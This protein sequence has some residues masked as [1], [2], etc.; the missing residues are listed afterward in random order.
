MKRLLSVFLLLPCLQACSSDESS[1]AD[2]QTRKPQYRVFIEQTYP[3]FIMHGGDQASGFE[4]ELLEAIAAKEGF[5]LSYT[6]YLWAGLFD[7]LKQDQADILSAGITITD[8]RKEKMLFS[9]PHFETESV[10][11]VHKQSNIKSFNDIIGKKIGAKKGTMQEQII[12]QYQKGYGQ[13]VDIPTTWMSVSRTMTGQTDGAL[14]DLGVMQYYAKQYGSQYGIEVVRD[15]KAVKE[16]L[17]FAVKLGNTELQ[18]KLNS[19]LTKIKADG[20]YER[21]YR[22]WFGDQH[23]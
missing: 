4:Y 6:P 7:A 20:N 9:D 23:K 10:L 15:P 12:Q 21:I 1:P 8:A 18:S 13:I 2:E 22:K 19:G 14:G 3:P 16:Q 17:A 5:T 11:L